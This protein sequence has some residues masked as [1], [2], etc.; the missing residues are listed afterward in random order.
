MEGHPAQI[1]LAELSQQIGLEN[2]AFNEDSVCCLEVAD[3]FAVQIEWEQTSDSLVFLS[4]VAEPPASGREELY[5]TLL[6][7]NF[8]FHETTGET[9]CLDPETGDVM[10]CRVFPLATTSTASLLTEFTYFLQTTDTWADRI[11]SG[12]P[13]AAPEDGGYTPPASFQFRA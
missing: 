13:S 12:T 9:L 8:L 3:R 5:R 10:L 6:Q 2:L 11:N 7:A 1:F 4:R